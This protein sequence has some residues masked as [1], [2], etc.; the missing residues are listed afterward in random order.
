MSE[1]DC[2]RAMPDFDL[3]AGADLFC[4]SWSSLGL[5]GLMLRH[6]TL[7]FIIQRFDELV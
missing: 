2:A 6:L 5:T 3:G 7:S 4:Q 1:E